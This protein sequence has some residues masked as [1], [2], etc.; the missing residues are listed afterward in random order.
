MDKRGVSLDNSW[1][2]RLLRLVI[3]CFLGT[4]EAG[5]GARGGEG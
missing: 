1:G 2:L 3:S 5:M 4:D